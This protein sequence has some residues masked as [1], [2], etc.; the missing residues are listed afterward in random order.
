M[1]A[2]SPVAGRV[3]GAP[4][5]WGV[6][7]VPDWG[8]QLGPEIVLRQ[9]RELGL[10]GTEFGPDGFLPDDPRAKAAALA[11]FGL[12]AVGQFVPVVLHDPG[13]DPLPD[14]ERAMEGL[15]AAH[16][17][18]VIIAAVSGVNGYDDRPVL[19]ESGWST[20]LGNLDRIAAAASGREL[21]AT[22]HPH[23]GTMI[24]S[25]EETERVLAGSRIALC[26]DT[27]HLLIGGGDPVGVAQQHPRRIAHIHLK[28]VR[29]DW[30]CRVQ[31]GEAT[32]TE[33]VAGGMYVP[34]GQ[35]DVDIG[36][37]VAALEGNGYA[38]W[39]VLEQDTILAGAPG[40]GGEGPDPAADVRASIRHLL[41]VAGDPA[42][43]SGPSTAGA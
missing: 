28:D 34:L 14:V 8:Y 11:E 22:L 19:D 27:G 20:L 35:G 41:A 13:H 10:A 2:A 25:G 12:K 26:L 9:M 40:D 1:P 43:T 5:S 3:A 21:V 4:I 33:A 31:S 17:S 6:C 16:A 24:S 18:T 7:E 23:V 36:C 15:V 37:I 42:A 38:G 30:A 32:Y 39:Y 29:I